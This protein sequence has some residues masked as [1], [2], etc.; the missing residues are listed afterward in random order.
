MNKF[1]NLSKLSNKFTRF[2]LNI[3][4][5]NSGNGRSYST[6]DIED[7]L[8]SHMD[9]LYSRFLND[10]ESIPIPDYKDP[11]FEELEWNN[12]VLSVRKIKKT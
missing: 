7:K 11:N 4:N 8:N 10:M 2:G 5:N 6:L 3:F 12:A 1:K 9:K